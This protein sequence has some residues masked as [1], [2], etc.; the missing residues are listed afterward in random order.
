MEWDVCRAMSDAIIIV[1]GTKN[2]ARLTLLI[3]VTHEQQRVRNDGGIV[4][5]THTPPVRSSLTS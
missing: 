3:I 5:L 2:D 1:K 4:V